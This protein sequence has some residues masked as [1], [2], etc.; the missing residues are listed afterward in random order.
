MVYGMNYLLK[1]L[2]H[3]YPFLKESDSTSLITVNHNLAV[4]FKNLFNHRGGYPRFKSRHCVRQSYTGHSTC[5]IE[6]K[7]RLRLPKLG[8]IRTSKT[9]QLKDYRIKRYTISHDPDGRYYISLNVETD[10][11]E[12]PRANRTVGIDAGLTDLA[13][14]SDGDKYATLNVNWL[15]NQV[16]NWQRKYSKRKNRAIVAVRQW[17]IGKKLGNKKHGIKQRL[18]ISVKTICKS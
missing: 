5:K 1:Q 8:S 17:K 11:D 18:L 2:K 4:A 12:L 16:A 6:A 7:R 14:T 3:D 13:I 9:N 10:I 15:E